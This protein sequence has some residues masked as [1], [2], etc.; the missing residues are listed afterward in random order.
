MPLFNQLGCRATSFSEVNTVVDFVSSC[1]SVYCPSRSINCSTMQ[2]E[3]GLFL[4]LAVWLFALLMLAL[5]AVHAVLLLTRLQET[6]THRRG[7]Q[8][9][10]RTEAREYQEV[11]AHRAITTGPGCGE[12]AAGPRSREP[13]ASPGRSESAT[14]SRSSSAIRLN[15]CCRSVLWYWSNKARM[16]L[17]IGYDRPL[18]HATK[19]H[20]S[21]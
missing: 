20:V 16:L 2:L 6:E 10:R 1:S 8:E 14:I 17:L 21:P 5:H 4:G 7:D 13:A 12:R 9:T 19:C 11:R 3:L 18:F 15:S